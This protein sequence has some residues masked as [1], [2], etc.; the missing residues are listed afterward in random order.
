MRYAIDVAEAITTVELY[1]T[2]YDPYFWLANRY[3]F[4]V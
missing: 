2:I 4:V 1:C 3:M